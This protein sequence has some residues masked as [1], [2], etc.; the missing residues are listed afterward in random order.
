MIKSVIFDIGSTLVHY[1]NPLNWQKLYKP[2]L[3]FVS[4]KCAL[5]LS[6]KN[7]QDAISI[8]NEYNTRLVPREKEVT[9][10]FIWNRIFTAWNKEKKSSDL[11]MCKNTFF[12]FFNNDCFIYDDVLTFL[13]FLR[14]KDIKIG[15][16]SDVAYGLENE[17]VLKDISSIL[18]FIDLPY[19]SNDVGFRK[20]NTKGLQMIAQKLGVDVGEIMFIG[21]EEKDI[22][23][24]NNAGSISVLIDR[25]EKY[26]E[27]GQKYRVKNLNELRS[28]F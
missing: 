11:Q 3:E 15:T 18:K 14:E 21:D 4:E 5:N 7:Y 25:D 24:A 13:P 20:P 27:F 19:T 23:C 22:I 6:E 2:A 26:P 16:L 10:T 8:L 12:S 9:A 17:Y 28:L 1:K